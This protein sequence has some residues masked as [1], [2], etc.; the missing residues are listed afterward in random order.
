MFTGLLFGALPALR[1]TRVSL[2]SAMKGS[3]AADPESHARFRPGKWIVASQV[4]LALVLL[5]ASGLFLRSLVKL[6]T[7]DIGFDRNNVL[8]VHANMHNAKVPPERQPA[9]FEEIENRLSTLPGV[10]SGS[11]SIM[12]P[13]SN[14]TWNNFLQADTPNP[15]T[16]DN[17]LAF[18]NYISPAYFETMRT[19][20]LAGRNFNRHDIQAAPLVAIVNESLARRFFPNADALG[21]YFKVQPDPE[22]P[23]R[24]LK[25][26]VW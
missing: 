9:M 18:F 15:P 19:P 24:P 4:A 13:S 16:G 2:T 21:K 26:L 11:R 23:L 22:N 20:L 1:S 25:L 14:F 6:V 12:T 5:V 3:Q 10:V 8:I 7:L 17:A